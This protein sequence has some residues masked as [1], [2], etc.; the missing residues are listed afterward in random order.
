[1]SLSIICLPFCSL[2]T[3]FVCNEM[4]YIWEGIYIQP[5]SVPV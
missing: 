4:N 3:T 1:M 2:Q 5:Y